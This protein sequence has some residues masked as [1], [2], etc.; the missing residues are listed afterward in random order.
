MRLVQPSSAKSKILILCL[1]FQTEDALSKRIHNV[2]QRSLIRH[3][4][5]VLVVRVTGDVL[6]FIEEGLRVDSSAVVVA[7]DLPR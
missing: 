7:K 2:L 3:V 4:E 1:T 6:D 5:E